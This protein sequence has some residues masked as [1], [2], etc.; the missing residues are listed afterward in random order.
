M[1]RGMRR[2]PT[3]YQDLIDII[4]PNQGHVV[5][6]T[7][8]LAGSLPTQLLRYRETNDKNLLQ[9]IYLWIEQMDNLFGHGNFFFEMQPSDNEEQ[10][11]VNKKLF[12]LSAKFNIDYVITTDSHY[13]K[14][15]DRVVHRTFLNAQDGE[16]EVDSFYAT[17][18][19]MDTNEIEHYFR[20]FS[21]EQLQTAYRNILKIKDMC[22]DFSLLRPLRIPDLYWKNFPVDEEMYNQL[23]NDIPYLE[24]FY[25]SDYQGDKKLVWAIL[26]GMKRKEGLQNK[27]AY[28]EINICLDDVWRSSIKNNVHW[29]AYLLNLQKNIDLCW[30]AGSLVGPGRGSGG[31]F[32]LLYLLDIIQ[33]NSLREETQ[34]YHWRF[35]NPERAS[36]LD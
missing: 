13:L 36:V 9:K 6:L 23:K 35:L 2:M 1:A 32:I 19:L 7:A 27:R 12:E 4:A 16:R 30:E 18:Y 28:K 31:G 25:N 24:T 11:Y 22:Q 10:I 21:G 34:V 17:T 20:Y 5:G 8:C 15:E 26:D 14:K 33:I 29:S 3:Y